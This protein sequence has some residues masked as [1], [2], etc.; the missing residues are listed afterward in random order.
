MSLTLTQAE[1][2][3]LTGKVQPA[4]Q[5]RRLRNMGI[6]A[7]RMDNPERPV[8]VCREWLSPRNA[9]TVESSPRLKSDHVQA[10]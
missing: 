5:L 10:V 8:C 1:I 2:F 7:Y 6:R 9:P 4:A 3:E